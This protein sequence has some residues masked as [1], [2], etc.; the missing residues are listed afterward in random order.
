MAKSCLADLLDKALDFARM[1]P[2]LLS[3]GQPAQGIANYFLALGLRFPQRS[4]A[5][6]KTLG[7]F[8]LLEFAK[9]ALNGLIEVVGRGYRATDLRP[10][11][12]FFFFSSILA[13]SF[14]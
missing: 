10:S 13:S 4:I 6:P 12:N 8:L 11:K 1:S 7:E 14:L 9:P 3:D 2:H 5:V